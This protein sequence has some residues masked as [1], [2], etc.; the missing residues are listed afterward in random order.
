MKNASFFKQKAEGF[1]DQLNSLN[2]K[3][4]EFNYTEK[5]NNDDYL[6]QSKELEEIKF[7][8]KLMFSE[9]DNG[10]VFLEKLNSFNN[11]DAIFDNQPKI[12]FLKGINKLF[13]DFLDEYRD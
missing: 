13:I 11:T 4:Y 2:P 3:Y 1:L 10:N 7:Q 6:N 5:Y 8:I 9:F 12:I